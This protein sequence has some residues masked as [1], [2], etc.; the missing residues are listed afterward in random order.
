MHGNLTKILA[1]ATYAFSTSIAMAA[2]ELSDST[3]FSL[4]QVSH[5]I[6]ANLNTAGF[7]T[8]LTAL[9]TGKLR[10]PVTTDPVTVSGQSIDPSESTVPEAARSGV[11]WVAPTEPAYFRY[12]LSSTPAAKFMT[13]EWS[14][15]QKL[16][17][18]LIGTI[19]EPSDSDYFGKDNIAPTWV[20]ATTTNEQFNALLSSIYSAAVKPG[21]SFKQTTL[22]VLAGGFAVRVTVQD[23]ILTNVRYAI[24]CYFK[25]KT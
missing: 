12:P 23:A 20:M 1:T 21:T 14:I 7:L 5:N 19:V 25:D 4:N 2:T 22:P 10:Q 6:R 3:E 18:C 11:V 16:N 24:T 17:S 9:G 8:H 13:S 15:R